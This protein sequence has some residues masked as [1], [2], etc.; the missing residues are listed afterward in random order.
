MKIKKCLAVLLCFMLILSS[1]P[2]TVLADEG[3]SPE[4]TTEEQTID[5]ETSEEESEA[6]DAPGEE[7]EPE[8]EATEEKPE[9]P[10]EEETSEQELKP[11]ES[12]EESESTEEL[13]SSEEPESS[14]EEYSK[15][16]ESSEESS[17][18]ESESETPEENTELSATEEETESQPEA[19]KEKPE[20]IAEAEE[21]KS[22]PAAEK[23]T[24]EQ[25]P[26][27][28][29]S[30][31]TPLS[32]HFNIEVRG[33]SPAFSADS[34]TVFANNHLENADFSYV[35]TTESNVSL[36][37]DLEVYN[38]YSESYEEDST[39][40][41]W[42]KLF[43][44]YDLN[45]D[46]VTTTTEAHGLPQEMLG[47]SFLDGS[48]SVNTTIPALREAFAATENPHPEIFHIRLTVSSWYPEGD[49]RSGMTIDYNELTL[50]DVHVP[51]EE[52]WPVIDY[53]SFTLTTLLTPTL[54]LPEGA[55][56]IVSLSADWYTFFYTKGYIEGE[57]E[58]GSFFPGPV[59]P[60]EGDGES[61][62]EY[63]WP[64]W[65]LE[66]DPIPERFARY[67]GN[68]ANAWVVGPVNDNHAVRGPE[69][70]IYGIAANKL[71]LHGTTLEDL[72]VS[73]SSFM[74][75][76]NRAYF[77]SLPGLSNDSW[78]G[79][80]TYDEISEMEDFE[81]YWYELLAMAD[82]ILTVTYSDG[83]VYT[84][85]LSFIRGNEDRQFHVVGDPIEVPILV[86]DYVLIVPENQEIA[87]GQIEN[88]LGF[89]TLQMGEDFPQ[90]GQVVV[91][92]N[93][94]AGFI[95]M[96]GRVE[97]IPFL[98]AGW[99]FEER[100]LEGTLSDRTSFTLGPQGLTA[101]P[102]AIYV[103]Q[104]DWELA[105][106]GWYAAKITFTSRYEVP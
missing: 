67:F 101:F 14:E 44:S 15:E 36:S 64:N 37:I 80:Y 41:I 57:D 98:L 50:R 46:A 9:T 52:F 27:P 66:S 82:C 94:D 2:I 16:Q 89:A 28:T 68:G 30:V 23:E 74:N 19:E 106:P 72:S 56:S 85:D 96:D 6:P 33:S 35:F 70:F 62:I 17:V 88:R 49:P 105:P 60:V 24:D 90:N 40:R 63:L 79:Y 87:Y 77:N 93:R 43:L 58:N 83:V 39:D 48:V 54:D 18:D 86:P 1:L 81:G 53:E 65:E 31:A 3:D 34:F 38:E 59:A 99:G 71:S 4:I 84:V 11:E 47:G 104:D 61:V 69:T 95:H 51:V 5:S 12:E 97:T 20:P 26:G 13:E 32:N 100:F 103:T 91:T 55:P 22:E 10:A 102:L 45:T 73:L 8:S 7:E 25:D 21:V 78:L 42:V 75:S 76:S 29:R 92:V